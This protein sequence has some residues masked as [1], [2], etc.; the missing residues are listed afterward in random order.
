[1]VLLKILNIVWKYC[2]WINSS[3]GLFYNQRK[4]K[5]KVVEDISNIMK[6]KMQL[7][8]SENKKKI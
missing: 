8:I 4:R 7:E 2:N 1:M 3:Y 6:K 5:E